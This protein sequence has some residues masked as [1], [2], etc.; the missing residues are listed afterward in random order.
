MPEVALGIPKAFYPQS[1][2]G[3]NGNSLIVLCA[4][5]TFIPRVQNQWQGLVCPDHVSNC[6]LFTCA[7]GLEG[8][9]A[10]LVYRFA[11]TTAQE[12]KTGGSLCV[13]IGVQPV[14]THSLRIA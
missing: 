10:G 8:S 13:S 12:V 7:A 2:I 1:R 5:F 4:L 14:S 3:S 6:A 9:L 11:I